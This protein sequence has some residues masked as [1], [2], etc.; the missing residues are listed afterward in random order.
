M[1]PG[2][3]NERR[4]DDLVRYVSLLPV[5]GA[6]VADKDLPLVDEVDHS[7][8]TVLASDVAL[9]LTVLIDQSVTSLLRRFLPLKCVEVRMAY[10]TDQSIELLAASIAMIA[11]LSVS[12]PRPS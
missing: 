11:S 12:M 5:P 10:R 3:R 2:S 4:A 1:L 7:W 8:S 6:A 9:T